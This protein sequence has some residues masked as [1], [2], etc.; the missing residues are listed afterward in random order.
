[1]KREPL[2]TDCDARCD[3][4]GVKYWCTASEYYLILKTKLYE[5]SD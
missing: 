2:Q 3:C 5:N 4:C 1:M